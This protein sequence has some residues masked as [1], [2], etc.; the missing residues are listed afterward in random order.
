MI[1][2]MVNRLEEMIDH[3][4]EVLKAEALQTWVELELVQFTIR[5]S[6]ITQ[7]TTTR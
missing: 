3:S 1:K 6:L 4:E 5:S 2:V 7:M